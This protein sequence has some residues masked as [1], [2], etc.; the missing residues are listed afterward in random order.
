MKIKYNS[1]TIFASL[2][3]VLSSLVSTAQTAGQW[4][5]MGGYLESNAPWAPAPGGP[6]P[7]VQSGSGN[8]SSS[9]KPGNREHPCGAIRT[10][11]KVYMFGGYGYDNFGSCGDLNDIWVYD[12]SISQWAW[13]KGGN[14]K[15]DPTHWLYGESPKYLTLGVENSSANPGGRNRMSGSTDNAGNLWVFG[16]KTRFDPDGIDDGSSG[17]Y[18]SFDA[19]WNNLWKFNPA[20]NNWTWVNGPSSWNDGGSSSL[21]RARH[22]VRSW[23][24]ATG[25]MWI[26]GGAFGS[27]SLNDLWKYNVST[28]QWTF[29]S[30]EMN[31]LNALGN[32]PP[33]GT[34]GTT[35]YPKGRSDYGYWVDNSGNFWI[36]GGYETPHST[37]CLGDLWKYTPSTNEWTLVKGSNAINVAPNHGT[38][39]VVNSSNNPGSRNAPYCWKGNDGNLY[40]FGG[41]GGATGTDW[42]ND[43]WKFDI[44]AN[45]WVW[46]GGSSSLNQIP[47]QS[48]LFSEAPANRPGGQVCTMNHIT[49]ATHSF[50]FS[51]YGKGSNNS[52]SD[53]NGGLTGSLWRIGNATGCSAPSA[54][55]LASTSTSACVTSPA[56]LTAVGCSGG[57]ISWNTGAT[58][59]SIVVTSAG[60]Y[61][62]NCTVAGCTSSNTT[63][64]ILPCSTGTTTACSYTVGWGTPTNET[65]VGITT[66]TV[67]SIGGPTEFSTDNISWNSPIVGTTNKYVFSVPATTACVSIWIRPTGCLDPSKVVWGCYTGSGYP[68]MASLC[69]YTVG[70]GTPSVQTCGGITS[71]TINTIGAPT[72]LS[73]DGT[74]WNNALIGTT[75][76]HTYTIPAT[77]A[78]VNFWTRPA[79][80]TD[81]SKVVWGCYLGSGYPC[82]LPTDIE[83][84]EAYLS[85]ISIYPNPSKFEVNI[86]G[87]TKDEVKEIVVKDILGRELIKQINS[88]NLNIE[89][90]A[91]GNYFIQIITRNNMSKTLRFI[92]E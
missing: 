34:S 3:L 22:R 80:C 33:I 13:V 74:T 16:G 14:Y 51:G 53:S 83:S 25:N 4:A 86:L 91:N 47:V 81:P 40:M 84:H 49:N 50:L 73:T 21:P 62:A 20:T 12:I 42:I 43:T 18:N 48:G 9:N 30:G 64:N 87:V 67:N 60:S 2:G 85:S 31:T 45:N 44:A 76:T 6:T 55:S 19:E 90:L 7:G 35:Y 23:F 65:C 66:F 58:G 89:S 78:C 68:C 29:V 5:W 8:F 56:T 28:N 36:Y 17:I 26:F 38:L 11:N 82:L 59:S 54:P 32:Y 79:G 27:T 1:I 37:N 61:F 57:V 63:F 15:D 41:A 71:Y 75:N 39:N 88:T 52:T 72:Q 92:K 10:D 77:S 70:W 46:V 69:S 24:D